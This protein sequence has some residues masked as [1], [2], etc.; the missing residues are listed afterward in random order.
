MAKDKSPKSGGSGIPHKHLHSR[1]S[2]LHQAASH[3]ATATANN[4]K[5]LEQANSTID[6]RTPAVR[7]ITSRTCHDS[8]RLLIQLRGVSRKSQIRLSPEVKHSIC[9]R[10]DALLIPGKTS[11]ESIVNSS[12]NG[13][14]VCADVLEIRCNKCETV[15]R[16]T[17]GVKRGRADKGKSKPGMEG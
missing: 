9:K 4:K 16:F 5:S 14:K 17:V 6:K 1:L 11:S 2:F 7:E 3:L 12:K 15:K 10:C 8:T 13:K